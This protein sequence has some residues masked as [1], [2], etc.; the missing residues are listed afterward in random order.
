VLTFAY[1]ED[2]IKLDFSKFIDELLLS[3]KIPDNQNKN[4]EHVAFELMHKK[5]I[6][7]ILPEVTPEDYDLR[8][9]PSSR[10]TNPFSY[11]F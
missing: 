5:I 7:S 3:C 10:H 4:I 11:A 1:L 9:G 2:F 6:K 8:T